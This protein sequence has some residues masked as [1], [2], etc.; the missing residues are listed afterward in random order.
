MNLLIESIREVVLKR[1]EQ[2][3]PERT[4][5]PVNAAKRPMFQQVQE[6]AL[7][8]VVG[9]I[10]RMPAAPGENVESIPIKPAPIGQ[11]R[12][13]PLRL[14][15]RRPHDDRPALHLILHNYITIL[16]YAAAKETLH[17]RRAGRGSRAKGYVFLPNRSL[18]VRKSLS[19]DISRKSG[20]AVGFEMTRAQRIAAGRCVIVQRATNDPVFGLG[21]CAG[22]TKLGLD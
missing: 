18:G 6:K 7:S 2:E 8:Q 10:G 5:E 22:G 20:S 13:P 11:S 12:L 9:V 15:L 21:F 3:R 17:L 19:A 14:T 4:L 1:G 16:R